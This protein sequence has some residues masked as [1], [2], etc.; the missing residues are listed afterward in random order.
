M[1]VAIVMDGN[2][3]WARAQGQPRLFGHREGANAVRRV[4]EAARREGIEVLTLFAFS[5]DNWKRPEEEVRGLMNLF[6]SFLLQ[7]MVCCAQNGV[8]LTVI[9]RRDRLSP[10]L[11][12]AVE[13]AESFTEGAIQANSASR[14][15]GGEGMLLRIAVDYSSRDAIL[16]AA[17]AWQQ[18]DRGESGGGFRLDGAG[19]SGR[20]TFSLL[21]QAAMHSAVPAPDVDLLIRTGGESRL[22]DFM[23]WECAYAELLFTPKMWPEFAA[24]DLR[25]ALGEFHSRQRR[26]GA[27]PE[28]HG[29]ILN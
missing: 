11:L 28:T 15:A 18:F 22:S 5:G 8:R 6:R 3:R 1:H 14:S 7:E 21:M 16:S 2:G 17:R 12:K 19:D 29:A 26:F 9:G 25:A 27:L 23:L 20:D 4:V 24:E 10:P 13:E